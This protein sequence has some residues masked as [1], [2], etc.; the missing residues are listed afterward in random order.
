MRIAFAYDVPYPWHI[1]G[2]EA[3]SFSEAEE[4]AKEND[5]HYFTTRWPGMKSG[6]FTYKG[7][8]Y[9][10]Y[11]NTDQGKIYRHGRRSV[12]E[13]IR[14]VMSLTR[15]YRYRFDVV[16]TNAF[17]ILH[18]PMLK[19]YCKLSGAKL[20]VQV[21]EVWDERYWKDYL[22]KLSGR[23]SYAYS[24]SAIMGADAYVT[25]SSVTTYKL[26]KFGV[27]RSR[28]SVFAPAVD[29]MVIRK[30]AAESIPK[31]KTVLFSGRLI[32]EKRIDV[33]LRILAGACRRDGRIHGLIVGSG[34][35]RSN[36]DR[37]IRS[38]GLGDR[39][40]FHNYYPDS[41][42]LYRQIRRSLAVLH[43][44]EREGLGILA[45]EGVMLGTPVL[46]P[47]YT[48]IPREVS[49]MCIVGSEKGLE[50][51][52]VG[53][54]SGREPK[55]TKDGAVLRSFSKSNVRGFYSGLFRKLG[56]GRG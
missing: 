9:H 17:P 26:A 18:L 37:R 1:G 3:M 51:V 45:I 42:Q 10:A 48:P 24:K 25:I 52:I 36:I 39:V 40:R 56:A 27:P 21:A 12:R 5:V 32:K 55:A 20:I 30:V 41:E 4:L 19:L 34:P 54:A 22:G 53:L 28:I 8:R 49:K 44:S 29:D 7:I 23:L 15:I 33:W 6:E 16:I 46:L 14:Y 50:D 11:S 13:A 47:E 2:I 38:M 43:T 31:S 35:D